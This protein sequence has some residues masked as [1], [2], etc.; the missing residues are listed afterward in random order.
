MRSEGDGKTTSDS[1]QRSLQGLLSKCGVFLPTFSVR[2]RRLSSD[3]DSPKPV[4]FLADQNHKKRKRASRSPLPS[5]RTPITMASPNDV[6]N[7]KELIKQLF[8][9]ALS[10]Q[11]GNTSQGTENKELQQLKKERDDL[12]KTEVERS[13][14]AEATRTASDK[15]IRTAVIVRGLREFERRVVF[16]NIAS[17]A[18]PHPDT[19]DMGGQFL[20]N[21]AKIEKD[22]ILFKHIAKA[23]PKGALLH[24][25]FNAELNPERLLAQARSM[26]N[27]FV[28]SNMALLSES[29]LLL[30]EMMFKIMP[31]TTKSNN[32]F[33]QDFKTASD[34]WKKPECNNSVWMRWSEFTEAFE[35][36]F[37]GK[38]VQPKGDQDQ[39]NLNLEP[40]DLKPAENWILQK[41]VLSEAEAYDPHQTVNGVWARFNQATRCFKGL[42][43]YRTVYEWYIDEAINR[44]I[45]EKVMYA[46]LRPMLLDKSIPSDNGEKQVDNAGQMQLILDCLETKKAKLA[47]EGKLHLFP[48]GLKIIYCTPRSIPKPLMQREMMDCIEL[49]SRFPKLI[50]GFDL[51]GAEDRPNHIG[52]YFEELVAFQKICKLKNLNIPFLFHAGETLLDTGGSTDPKNSNLYDAVALQSKR[53]GHGFSLLKHPQLVEKFKKTPNS[54]GICIELCPIS[55]ELL[56]LCRNI[57]EHPYPEL[58]AA[59]I[60]CTVNS[61]NPSLFSNSMSHEFYQIMVGS[62]TIS[63]HSWKQLALWSLEYS[64]L[65]E[66]EKEQGKI[67]FMDAWNDFCDHVVRKYDHL[68]KIFVNHDGVEVQEQGPG[69]REIS[70]NEINEIRARREYGLP[71]TTV[72]TP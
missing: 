72:T 53:V 28:W 46:E 32:I 25:H 67:Y 48:F 20:T 47:K 51:V 69:V 33:S 22:S 43:N 3:Q 61:D 18:I 57:K 6:V 13:W 44:M 42:V 68:F 29:D 5:T 31:S 52:Y 54:P 55:N 49:K 59:G 14:D 70:V 39:L 27:M 2:G 71:A 62:P 41:M 21:K 9:D 1:S 66:E 7:E 16:G 37:P 60:P 12:V 36:K 40:I 34:S 19:R 38:Y 64:C 15:E 56:H 4:M 30:T 10:P 58:L 45:D 26:E 50:C 24:L 17:E 23:V 8:N 11:Q 65:S 35:N 63:V